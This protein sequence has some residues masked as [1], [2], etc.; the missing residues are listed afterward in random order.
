MR[1]VLFYLLQQ[2]LHIFVLAAIAVFIED[3]SEGDGT[4]IEF[5]LQIA[6][7]RT[8]DVDV[9]ALGLWLAACFLLL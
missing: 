4:K 2:L 9:F 8:G 5:L 1:L 3:S 7:F 6:P